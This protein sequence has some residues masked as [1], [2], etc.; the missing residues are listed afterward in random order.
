MTVFNEWLSVENGIPTGK[1]FTL[2]ATPRYVRNGRDL[3]WWVHQ[4]FRYQAYLS[5]ALLLLS[6]GAP[7]LSPGNYS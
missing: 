7:A 4:D 3:A 2:D 6:Y 1:V 5:A